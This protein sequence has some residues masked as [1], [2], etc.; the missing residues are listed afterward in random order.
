MSV[1]NVVTTLEK[2]SGFDSMIIVVTQS[3]TSHSKSLS[4]AL[5]FSLDEVYISAF[6]NESVIFGQLD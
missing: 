1:R 5:Y 3:L 4:L 6:S 2:E